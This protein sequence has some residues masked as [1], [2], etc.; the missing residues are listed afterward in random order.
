VRLGERIGGP[1]SHQRS[2]GMLLYTTRG[3]CQKGT[4]LIC[5]AFHEFLIHK[6][7][8]PVRCRSIAMYRV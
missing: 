6:T 5:C 3:K 2:S 8:L 7:P 1:R 4:T